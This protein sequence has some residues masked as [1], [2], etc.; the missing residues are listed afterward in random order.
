ML[1]KGIAFHLPSTT[2]ASLPALYQPPCALPTSSAMSPTSRYLLLNWITCSRPFI[3]MSA[4]EPVSAIVLIRVG[5]LG[6]AQRRRGA[7]GRDLEKA[8]PVRQVIGCR[9]CHAAPP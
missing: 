6:P 1:A 5:R 4:P 7:R 2:T 8:P 9:P 3:V